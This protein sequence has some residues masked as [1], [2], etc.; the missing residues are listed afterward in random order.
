MRGRNGKKGRKVE[1]TE[2]EDTN[3]RKEWMLLKRRRE[4]Q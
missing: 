3:K 2:R 1:V 4:R